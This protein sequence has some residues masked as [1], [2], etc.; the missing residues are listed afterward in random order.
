[1]A[2]AMVDPPNLG[3]ASREHRSNRIRFLVRRAIPH[4]L[5]L[6]WIKGWRRRESNPRI[7]PFDLPDLA[8]LL[9]HTSIPTG[10]A[11]A[12]SAVAAEASV[13]PSS[14]AQRSAR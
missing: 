13:D 1:M 8:M 2:G 14:A 10:R 3:N 6:A 4:K 7:I 12:Q 9:D 11:I 5:D